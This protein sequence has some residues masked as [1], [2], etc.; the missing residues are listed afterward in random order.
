MEAVEA[1]RI[2][3]EEEVDKA[4]NRAKNRGGDGTR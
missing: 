1:S 4:R 2:D 3:I